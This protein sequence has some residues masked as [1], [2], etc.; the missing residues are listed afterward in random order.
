[1]LE[2]EQTEPEVPVR[3]PPA[4]ITEEA[5]DALVTRV[6]ARLGPNVV[7]EVVKEVVSDIAE[8]LI[9]EEIQRIRSKTP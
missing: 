5:L 8:R 1:M 2:A 4:P 9:R 6:A 7:R 3:L